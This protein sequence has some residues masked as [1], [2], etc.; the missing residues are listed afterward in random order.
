MEKHEEERMDM[1]GTPGV[2]RE[3]M[4]FV[5]MPGRTTY[6]G[7]SVFRSESARFWFWSCSRF[8]VRYNYLS[9]YMPN[10]A[11]KRRDA[12]YSAWIF[13]SA[14]QVAHIIGN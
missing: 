3:M 5:D 9:V 8:S 6:T 13:S 10:W 11:Y 12:G 1:V 7:C 2:A 14:G 4:D